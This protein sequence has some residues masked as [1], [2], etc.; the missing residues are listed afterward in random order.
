MAKK[1]ATEEQALYEFINYGKIVFAKLFTMWTSMF[2]LWTSTGVAN[3]FFKSLMLITIPQLLYAYSIRAKYSL[4]SVVSLLSVII[5]LGLFFIGFLGILGKITLVETDLGYF[6]TI[7]D[8]K[9]SYSLVRSV[10]V[11][12]F[13]V[14]ALSIIYIVE[15]GTGYKAK[16]E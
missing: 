1:Q 7:N 3:E 4:R 6:L 11:V 8:V 2:L 9:S 13:M 10:S 5:I 14:I 15:W 12:Y 16:G